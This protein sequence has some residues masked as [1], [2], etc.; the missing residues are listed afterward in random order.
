MAASDSF[1][2]GWNF[3]G[4]PEELSRAGKAAAWV[5]PVPYEATTS[6]G[7]GTRN[8]PAAILAAS[9][10]VELYD[11]EFD[12][13]PASEFGVHTLPA[14]E[15]AHDSPAAMIERTAAAVRAVLS[16]APAPRL[17]ALLGGEHSLTAGAVRGTAAAAPDEDLVCVQIDAHADLRDEYE[18]SAYSHACAA[19]RILDTCPL[20]Q[21]GVRNLSA[22]GAAF[23]RRNDRVRTVF[24]RDALRDPSFPARLAE[25]VRGK[26]VYLTIDVDGL[27]PAIMPAVGTPEPGGLSWDSMLDIAR[28]VCREAARLRVFDV[29]ELAPIPG[30]AAPDFL[31]ARLAYKIMSLALMPEGRGAQTGAQKP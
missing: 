11:P 18:G 19:R 21:V 23:L 3:L 29:V 2:A 13:E 27:D 30:L 4:L 22:E 14:L 1:Q 26:S 25:F 16:G 20:F 28:T 17:L 12:C 7:A 10:Q 31:C 6:Y 8:G 9:R 15:P 5:L 24:A